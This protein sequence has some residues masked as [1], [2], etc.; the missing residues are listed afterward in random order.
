MISSCHGFEAKTTWPRLLLTWNEKSYKFCPDFKNES[1]FKCWIFLKFLFGVLVASKKPLK[2][3]LCWIKDEYEL[4]ILVT[5]VLMVASLIIIKVANV[6]MHPT[7]I[8]PMTISTSSSSSPP[9]RKFSTNDNL[10]I[11]KFVVILIII[12]FYIFIK[13]VII[14]LCDNPELRNVNSFTRS[15]SLELNFTPRKARK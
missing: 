5:K 2:H 9:R 3:H 1:T 11:V 14:I 10:F 6:V 7:K 8:Q 4:M 13:T 12:T 15:K